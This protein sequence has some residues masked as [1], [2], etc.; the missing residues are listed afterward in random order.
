MSN[1]YSQ[2]KPLKE[3]VVLSLTPPALSAAGV[4]VE[5]SQLAAMILQQLL[6][7]PVGVAYSNQALQ[8]YL[9]AKGMDFPNPLELRELIRRLRTATRLV[10][11]DNPVLQVGGGLMLN[12]HVNIECEADQEPDLLD[13]IYT[14]LTKPH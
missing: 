9:E 12:H 4:R 10:G 8:V 6:Q 13:I 1:L 7:Q 2:P 3:P 5:I 11:I 14:Q